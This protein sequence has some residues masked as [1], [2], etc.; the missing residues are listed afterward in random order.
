MIIHGL[1]IWAENGVGAWWEGGEHTCAHAWSAASF[2][3]GLPQQRYLLLCSKRAAWACGW[4][5]TPRVT[6]VRMGPWLRARHSSVPLGE[7]MSP[8]RVSASLLINSETL[9]PSPCLRRGVRIHSL[10]HSF[11]QQLVI[12]CLQYSR[13]CAWYWC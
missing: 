1:A 11:F 5:G 12:K 10:A 9:K 3:H 13:F 4:P 7:V 6:G 2:Y 8:L